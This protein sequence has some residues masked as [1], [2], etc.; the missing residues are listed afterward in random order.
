VA[1][2]GFDRI[3]YLGTCVCGASTRS[4][5]KPSPNNS[6]SYHVAIGPFL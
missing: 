6:P 1:L 5:H 2:D 4:V 3:Y